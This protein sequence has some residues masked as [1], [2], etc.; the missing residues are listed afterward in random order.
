MSNYTN[1]SKVEVLAAVEA[2]GLEGNARGLFGA[3]MSASARLALRLEARD[4]AH[5]QAPAEW[6]DAQRAHFLRGYQREV[7]ETCARIQRLR[8]MLEREG[9]R[10]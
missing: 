7:S 2:S 3:L 5:A 4:A 9:A 6:S 8:D 10:A 1:I